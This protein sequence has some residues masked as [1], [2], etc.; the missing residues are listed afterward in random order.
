[1]LLDKLLIK[2]ELVDKLGGGEGRLRHG[3]VSVCGRERRVMI[4]LKQNLTTV[5]SRLSTRSTSK[6][7]NEIHRTLFELTV[8]EGCGGGKSIL[9]DEYITR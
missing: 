8:V 9:Y 1:M 2:G 7:E 5:Y 4:R 3:Q 6:K